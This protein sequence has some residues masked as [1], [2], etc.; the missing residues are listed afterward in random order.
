MLWKSIY[1]REGWTIAEEVIEE[2]EQRLT[3]MQH[4]F[5]RLF[6][7]LSSITTPASVSVINYEN[8]F[9]ASVELYHLYIEFY[10]T[11][12]SILGGRSTYTQI[13]LLR[14]KFSKIARIEVGE[15]FYKTAM[16]TLNSDGSIRVHVD[17]RYLYMN[18][19]LLENNWRGGCYQA[20][21]LDG[22]PDVARPAPREGIYCV[23]FDRRYLAAGCRDHR[24]RLWSMATM[25]YQKTL[26]SHEGSVLCLQ[27]DSKRNLLVSRI[28]QL[29]TKSGTLNE[30][31][32]SKP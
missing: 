28:E 21:L 15:S 7:G 2:F 19:N 11:V 20:E 14:S 10:D 32:P 4:K 31:K 25:E 18:R 22:A 27:L 8:T 1:S 3:Q 23:Y 24:I 29:A 6:A 5:D 9:P 17:W 30:A 26:Q 13:L 12:R 16:F